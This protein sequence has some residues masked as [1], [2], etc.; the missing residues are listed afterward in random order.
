[1]PAGRVRDMVPA[2]FLIGRSVHSPEEAAQATADGSV[3]YLV[4]GT[5]FPT[6]SKPGASVAGLAPLRAAS[7]MTR[8]PVLAVGGLT[9]ERM[10]AV[11]SAG[12]AGVAAI[13]LFSDPPIDALKKAV[14]DVTL[15][16]D[17]PGGVA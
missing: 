9:P 15:S 1:M 13:R 14:E 10:T 17:T 16:F 12:A 6:L 5:V 3:D 8:V 7:G 2:R 11:A 4:F